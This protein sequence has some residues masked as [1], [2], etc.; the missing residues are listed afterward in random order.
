MESTVTSKLSTLWRAASNL[1]GSGPDNRVGPIALLI[2]AGILVVP[3]LLVLLVFRPFFDI[4]FRPI[5]ADRLGPLVLETDLFISQLENES[6]RVLVLSFFVGNPANSFFSSLVRKKVRVVAPILG[7]TG[8]FLQRS[9]FRRNLPRLP[10]SLQQ[11]RQ[12]LTKNSFWVPDQLSRDGLESLLG[13]LGVDSESPYVCLWVRDS[14]FGTLAMPGTDQY[15]ARYRNASIENYHLMCRTLQSRGYSVIRMGRAGISESADS[16]LPYADYLSSSANCERNDFLLAKYCSF[17]VCGDSGSTSIP[18]LYRRP[19]ALTNLGSFIGAITAESVRVLSM[20]RI[21]WIDTGAP[22]TSSEISR[23]G[24]NRFNDTNQ[25][26]TLGIRHVE[27]TARQLEGIAL[28][29]LDLMDNEID[30]SVAAL[31]EPQ[32]RF[33]E[34]IRPLLEEEPVFLGGKVWLEENLQFTE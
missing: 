10:G 15:F 2:K 33:R 23:F 17:A 30:A 12:V 29:M 8:Y 32:L 4:R 24:I 28:D 6:P 34:K 7:A 18:L 22:V 9:V 3:V 21:E 27:N 13:G 5:Y 14:V 16:P 11:T 25:F 31:T 1:E 26:D 20:K 19:I